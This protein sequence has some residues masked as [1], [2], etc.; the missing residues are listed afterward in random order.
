MSRVLALCL[1]AACGASSSTRATAM[2]IPGETQAR[3]PGCT[4]DG[5]TLEL[6]PEPFTPPAWTW[7]GVTYCTGPVRG[8]TNTT[9]QMIR[10]WS[11]DPAVA[12]VLAWEA[13]N[14]CRWEQTGQLQ[15]TGCA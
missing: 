15:D 9:Q 13:C 11:G 1:L 7:C 6:V 2:E 14:A 4:L 10:V 5:W 8:Y 12:Q 3:W